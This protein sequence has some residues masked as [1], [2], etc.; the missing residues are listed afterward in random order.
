MKLFT[1]LQAYLPGQEISGTNVKSHGDVSSLSEMMGPWVVLVL[2]SS[3]AV[4]V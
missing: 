2:G 1:S 3:E 4:V